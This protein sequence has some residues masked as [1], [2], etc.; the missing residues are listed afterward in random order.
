MWAL[1]GC[2]ESPRDDQVSPFGSGE[3]P[4]GGTTGSPVESTSGLISESMSE[5]ISDTSPIDPPTTT[6]NPATDATSPPTTA[7]T[8]TDGDE[9]GSSGDATGTVT[10]DGES[11]TGGFD[12]S[13]DGVLMV[14]IMPMNVWETGE[15]NDVVVTNVSGAEVTWTVDLDLAGTINQAWNC[16]YSEMDQVG[17]F[18]GVG[19][20]ATLAADET[21]TF[22]FCVDY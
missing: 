7:T 2:G 16:V 8:T 20:N 18:S 4:E 1:A 22:G 10:T 9:S 15:C 6:T 17:S 14:E 19:F 13:N 3:T 5:S 12:T 11:S 21:A